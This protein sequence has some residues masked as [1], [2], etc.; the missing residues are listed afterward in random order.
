MPATPSIT[1]PQDKD[2]LSSKEQGE[3]V[4]LWNALVKEMRAK[5]QQPISF[6]AKLD[7]VL[8]QELSLYTDD[9]MLSVWLDPYT[10]R[11]SWNCVSQELDMAEPW[12][13]SAS[14]EFK[15]DGESMNL[16]V[17]ADRFIAKLSGEW[18]KSTLA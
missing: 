11:G 12:S 5:I 14:G 1:H 8:P 18:K 3:L 6:N 13:L 15:L 10:G 2:F 17:A 7:E 9:G 16:S 4:A